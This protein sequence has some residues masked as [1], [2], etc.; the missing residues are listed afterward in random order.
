MKAKQI[1]REAQVQV[2]DREDKYGPPDKMLER[3]SEII[4]LVLDY[5]V[6]PQQAGIILI[7]LKLTRLIETPDHYD[8]IVDVAGYAGVL[9]ESTKSQKNDSI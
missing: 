4:S 6:T 8:S 1:L 3:F 5:H 7:G 2:D 9:G